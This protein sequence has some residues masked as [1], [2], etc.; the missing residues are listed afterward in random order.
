MFKKFGDSYKA[1]PVSSSNY[2]FSQLKIYRY[3]ELELD[4]KE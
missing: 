3:P 1:Q 4:R 2:S